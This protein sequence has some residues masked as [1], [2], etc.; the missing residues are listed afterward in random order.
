VKFVGQGHRSKFK[1]TGGNVPFSAESESE[2]GKIC[3]GDVGEKQTWIRNCK[4]VT[5][6]AK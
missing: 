4:Y 2:L 6:A 3:S 5:P 1:I